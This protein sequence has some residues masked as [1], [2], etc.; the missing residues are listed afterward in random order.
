[1][2]GTVPRPWK[3]SSNSC[4]MD[5]RYYLYKSRSIKLQVKYTVRQNVVSSRQKKWSN[6]R[7]KGMLGGL[8]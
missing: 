7:K 3:Y 6:E 1:M 8:F 2:V 4:F 5:F